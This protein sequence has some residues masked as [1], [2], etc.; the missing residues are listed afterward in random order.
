MRYEWVV[1]QTI[2][3]KEE[4]KMMVFKPGP[5]GYNP[6][7]PAKISISDRETLEVYDIFEKKLFSLKLSGTE[8]GRA[9]V[10][11]LAVADGKKIDLTSVSEDCVIIKFAF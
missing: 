1:S 2:F 10:V 7:F 3:E 5:E 6:I 11:S 4:D 9:P 8:A